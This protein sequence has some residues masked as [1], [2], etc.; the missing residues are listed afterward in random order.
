MPAVY[1]RVQLAVR[2]AER[3]RNVLQQIHQRRITDVNV[4]ALHADEEGHKVRLVLPR[5][6]ALVR[7]LMRRRV[8]C[9]EIGEID[10]DVRLAGEKGVYARD[11]RVG[12]RDRQHDRL[13]RRAERRDVIRLF[14]VGR[15]RVVELAGHFVIG[16]GHIRVPA[17]AVCDLVLYGLDFAAEPNRAVAQILRR[18][19]LP[20]EAQIRIQPV[21]E[22]TGTEGQTKI[23]KQEEDCADQR[24]QAA[25][26]RAR[27]IRTVQRAVGVDDVRR[28]QNRQGEDERLGERKGD[29]RGQL[30]QYEAKPLRGI[31]RPELRKRGPKTGQYI[32]EHRAAE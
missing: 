15:K 23:G 11:V 31:P 30:R 4:V 27:G 18:D 6:A 8:G 17:R 9:A 32:Y 19:R 16:I 21:S 10:V 3:A 7:H 28:R 20:L 12:H 2:T 26:E 14:R 25:P 1:R 13:D 24:H 29:P 22:I 5:D